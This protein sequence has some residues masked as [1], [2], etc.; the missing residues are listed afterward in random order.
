MAPHSPLSWYTLKQDA[1]TKLVCFHTSC[2]PSACPFGHFFRS[3]R[4]IAAEDILNSSARSNRW[5]SGH[6]CWLPGVVTFGSHFLPFMRSDWTVFAC[7]RITF[8]RLVTIITSQAL[9]LIIA[10]VANFFRLLS[11]VEQ[12]KWSFF[13]ASWYTDVLAIIDQINRL[14]YLSSLKFICIDS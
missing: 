2:I 14:L 6:E 11:I 7:F 10:D 5:E 4:H 13:D 12:F 8:L 9:C 1:G 3:K